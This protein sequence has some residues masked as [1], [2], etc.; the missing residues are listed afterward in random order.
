M[1][2]IDKIKGYLSHWHS[3]NQIINLSSVTG[4]TLTTAL[5]N[6]LLGTSLPDLWKANTVEIRKITGHDNGDDVGN[7]SD[8]YVYE[9]DSTSVG[10]DDNTDTLKPS[11][12][13]IV[14]TIGDTTASVN[15]RAVP[16][17]NIAFTS[18]LQATPAAAA[19]ALSG[20]IDAHA[21]F[22]SSVSGLVITVTRDVG[23][24]G[25]YIS[26]NSLSAGNTDSTVA[27]R[28]IKKFILV[29]T[30]IA[31]TL[32]NKTLVHGNKVYTVGAANCNYTSIQAALTANATGGEVFLVQPGSYTDTINFTANNQCVIGI[33]DRGNVGAAIVQVYQLNATVVSVGAFTGCYINNIVIAQLI[34]A[35][36]VNDVID[37]TSGT[38]VFIN[39]II[40]TTITAA[41]SAVRQPAIGHITTTGTIHFSD[42]CLVS[43]HNSN[44]VNF[45]TMQKV[46]FVMDGNG[47]VSGSDST[48]S[49]DST[50]SAII[51]VTALASYS[52]NGD[53]QFNRCTIEID[54]DFANIVTGSGYL[55]AGTHVEE[56]YD[57]NFRIR[58]DANAGALVTA[59]YAN[60]AGGRV[61]SYRNNIDVVNTPTPTQ[62]YSYYQGNT[63]VLSVYDDNVMYA[64]GG[65]SG[66]ITRL[67]TTHGLIDQ[68]IGNYHYQALSR[69]ADTINDRRTINT[70]GVLT[71]ERCTV[72]N[73]AKGAGTWV[74]DL[75]I[76]AAGGA[77]LGSLA[78]SGMVK[79]TAGALSAI[80]ASANQVSYWSDANTVAGSANFTWDATSLTET[81]IAASGAAAGCNLSLV[82]NDGTVAVNGERLGGLRF[83]GKATAQIEL[84]ASIQAFATGTWAAAT[85]IP[86]DLVFSTGSTTA[87]NTE[88]MRITSAG[89][90]G[91][92]CTPTY[93]LDINNNNVSTGIR[94]F[95]A[96][97]TGGVGEYNI[98]RQEL[99]S[100]AAATDENVI[101][102]TKGR[103]AAGRASCNSGDYIG[104][105]SYAAQIG[106]GVDNYYT[107][108]TFRALVDG[109]IVGN[110]TPTAFVWSTD[111]GTTLAER[112]RITST[113]ILQANG[114]QT[115]Q[116]STG[117]LTLNTLA[118]N[119][120][121]IFTTHGTGAVQ[122]N[123][124]FEGKQGIDVASAAAL[125]LGADGNVFEIT[126]VTAV[127]SITAT[128]WQEGSVIV[129]V[130]NEN[131]TI[132]HGGNIKLAGSVDYAMTAND[133][134]T[135][136]L[137]S[138][139]AG[140]QAWREVARTAI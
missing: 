137:C 135:M 101:N 116:T 132:T 83:Y 124:R 42:G 112:W 66:T 44:N 55:I 33:G 97:T 128:S 111:N 110:H 30:A 100:S 93:R 19:A 63:I 56:Y 75:T 117:N 60:V 51:A 21:S 2:V 69:V 57:C 80:T 125:T 18:G 3:S 36:V 20:L 23:T 94:L 91:I 7:Y 113:G 103:Y 70:A 136:C 86:T 34:D 4:S 29:D 78:G 72:A 54:D 114:A 48:F 12:I 133:T 47:Y 24:P 65:T 45:A 10:Q 109:A 5:N 39:C 11:D 122:C 46:P 134:L 26:S 74:V 85:F 118:G 131:V 49:I 123:T 31:Q 38:I 138:T 6:L 13:P 58:R 71:M 102:F 90:V 92:N 140:G 121:I 99:Y 16:G 96:N 67:N 37:V 43:Y 28:F 9:Y 79:S 32:S 52:G 14:F 77:T 61:E 107:C 127:T 81:Y 88:R 53:M 15:L 22:V 82:S 89:D 17:V 129:L 104:V 35:A 84:G 120:N 64:S 108:A 27:G 50:D 115:I 76:S 95:N 87:A 119:G 62:A 98:F 8:G 41:I 40:S 130:A 73:V 105:L 25:G 126:G 68:V 139:T 1:G 106:A 59:I